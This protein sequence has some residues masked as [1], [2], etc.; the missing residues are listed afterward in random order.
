MF[1]AGFARSTRIALIGLLTLRSWAIASHNTA[2]TAETKCC[3]IAQHQTAAILNSSYGD[4]MRRGIVRTYVA[5]HLVG[6][7]RIG[8]TSGGKVHARTSTRSAVKRSLIAIC[9]IDDVVLGM[10]T[11]IH[12]DMVNM[13]LRKVLVNELVRRSWQL[14]GVDCLQLRR[15]R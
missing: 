10:R 11:L 14:F 4:N 9:E 12:L 13:R 7:K 6:N 1:R 2:V 3:A 8:D 15:C 5:A